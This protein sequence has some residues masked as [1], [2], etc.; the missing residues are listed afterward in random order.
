MVLDFYFAN[1]NKNFHHFNSFFMKILA[2]PEILKCFENKRS[3]FSP[4]GLTC[5]KWKFKKMNR[6]DRHNEIELNYVPH[7]E[8]HYLFHDRKMIVPEGSLIVFW[9]LQPHKV[10][11]TDENHFYYVATIPLSLFMNWGL[12]GSFVR[13]ILNG[14]CLL[15]SEDVP[16]CYDTFLFERWTCDVRQTRMHDLVMLEMHARL[17][18]MATGYR[19][20]ESVIR[21]TS[22]DIS[23]IEQMAVYIARN[24]KNDIRMADIG[25]HVG[26]NPEYANSLF[27]KSFGHTLCDHIAMERISHAQ[28]MLVSTNESIFKIGID[29]GFNSISSFN[30]SFRKINHCTPSEYR[31]QN[32]F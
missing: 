9:G 20:C 31:K 1:L 2:N 8:L 30:M 21:S 13:E 4:Y 3:E 14:V 12:P 29:C 15:D 10:I 32:Q 16:S 23:R 25:K 6:F 5:E 11:N 28:R 27:R 26:L 22:A 24:Y 19:R 17:L 18:R 7:G